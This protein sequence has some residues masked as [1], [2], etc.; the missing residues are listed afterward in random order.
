MANQTAAQRVELA[1][2]R[3]ILVLK[4][5]G[6]SSD[7]K[8]IEETEVVNTFL[9]L[10]HAAVSKCTTQNLAKARAW[11]T[12]NISPHTKRVE[13]L[14]TYL[15]TY[16]TELA[17]FK[18]ADGSLGRFGTRDPSSLRIRKADMFIS[19]ANPLQLSVKKRKLALLLFI[20]DML[21]HTHGNPRYVVS[22][23]EGV[24]PRLPHFIDAVCK[25]VDS[26]Y[27]DNMASHAIFLRILQHWLDQKYFPRA[28]L[29]FLKETGMKA[30]GITRDADGD[31]ADNGHE[32]NVVLPLVHG[33]EHHR[34]RVPWQKQPAT[35]QFQAREI[36]NGRAVINPDLIRP[37]KYE[38]LQA[39]SPQAIKAVEDILSIAK[40]MKN[41]MADLHVTGID[42]M[43]NPV[44]KGEEAISQMSY[45]G[46]S[47]EY[48]DAKK[49]EAG[50]E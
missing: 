50:S 10:L 13:A 12:R 41:K 22:V 38:P 31:L 8:P 9:P 46:W 29:V 6:K 48:C 37:I 24:R 16:A 1:G 49:S 18:A 19:G 5:P 7:V 14:V 4:V 47:Q 39:A 36:K 11:A 42:E 32:I 30:A 17:N 25:N 33:I 23:V 2:L 21:A 40:A 20:N 15:V 3:F 43:G 34:A 45:Y 27:E 35:V 26:S 44:V 28:Y